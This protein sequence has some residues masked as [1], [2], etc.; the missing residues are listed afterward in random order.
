MAHCL[1]IHFDLGNVKINAQ[2]II[3]VLLLTVC[4]K[5]TSK[6]VE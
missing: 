2:H 5:V 6:M 4:I 1:Q 3:Y